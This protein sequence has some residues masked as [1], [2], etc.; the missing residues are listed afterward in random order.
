MI[1]FNREKC[2][3]LHLGK[4]N[5]KHKYYIEEVDK[6]SILEETVSEKDLGVNINPE[7]TF[8]SHI[9]TTVKKGR[10]MIGIIYKKT[11]FAFLMRQHFKRTNIQFRL[12][13]CPCF[14]YLLFFSPTHLSYSLCL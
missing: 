2:K 6:V 14:I 1:K 3:I 9:Y 7:L 11:V 4:E 10:R 5:P 8:Y 12:G 13:V